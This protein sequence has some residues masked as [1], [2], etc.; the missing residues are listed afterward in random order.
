[1]RRAGEALDSI[2]RTSA[3]QTAAKHEQIDVRAGRIARPADRPRP[4]ATSV[5][6]SDTGFKR[7]A[8]RQV[9]T[10][11]VKKRDVLVTGAEA[12][13][14]LDI[15]ARALETDQA[16]DALF[17]PDALKPARSLMKVRGGTGTRLDDA[18]SKRDG[19]R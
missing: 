2:R 4:V 14:V 5:I 3:A 17:P 1:M 9:V 18:P 10:T 6:G 11:M 12:Q 19:R 7:R 13:A 16:L 8:I 15:L